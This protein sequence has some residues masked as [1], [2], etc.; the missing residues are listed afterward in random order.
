MAEAQ[1]FSLS[2]RVVHPTMSAIEIVQLIGLSPRISSSVGE[3][4]RTP[5]GAEL[6]GVNR[7]TFVTFPL[8]TSGSSLEDCLDA[9]FVEPF[10][11]D[12]QLRRI[13][14]TGGRIEFFVGMS[15]PSNCGFELGPAIMAQ[16]GAKG[17][18]LSLDMYTERNGETEGH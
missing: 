6:P 11:S 7:R 5:D 10:P 12:Q 17:L 1:V 2:L 14:D 4:R 13:I 15:G 16:L 8:D 18:C 3:T 9:A